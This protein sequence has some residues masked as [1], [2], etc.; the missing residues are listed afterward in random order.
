MRQWLKNE[1]ARAL[2]TQE[3]L[4]AKLGVCSSSIAHWESG[5]STPRKRDR[6][7][8]AQVLGCP[9]IVSRFDSERRGEVA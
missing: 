1:R 9:E 5:L 4:A 7:G 3:Q 8:L 2:L 6:E